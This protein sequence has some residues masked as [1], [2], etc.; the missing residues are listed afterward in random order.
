MEEVDEGEFTSEN[1]EDI[2]DP[3]VGL[4]I[5]AIIGRKKKKGI[6]FYY[7]VVGLES[8]KHIWVQIKNSLTHQVKKDDIEDEFAHLIA[9]YE[10]SIYEQKQKNSNE[11]KKEAP[12][13]PPKNYNYHPFPKIK[14]PKMFRNIQDGKWTSSRYT[15]FHPK[16]CKKSW[17][18][19]RLSK[20]HLKPLLQYTLSLAQTLLGLEL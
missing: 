14:Q 10:W 4:N 8:Q 17:K 5:V 9:R 2:Y 6:I 12:V 11:K 1:N 15:K 7:A 16:N 18:K 20:K 13:H 19:K 3:D